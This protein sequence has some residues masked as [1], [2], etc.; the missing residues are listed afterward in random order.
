MHDQPASASKLPKSADFIGDQGD[1]EA[2]IE[3]ESDG[4]WGCLV[5]I[6]GLLKRP[7]LNG[8]LGICESYIEDRDR[9]V[10]QLQGGGAIVKLKA[11]NVQW[12]EEEEEEEVA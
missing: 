10:V 8:R 4:L 7:E 3:L 5:R 6:H 2:N 12:V 9:W 1:M 11:E